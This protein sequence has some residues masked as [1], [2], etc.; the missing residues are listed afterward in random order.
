MGISLKTAIG[1][2]LDVFGK[3]QRNPRRPSEP[4]DQYRDR[5]INNHGDDGG[6]AFGE[7]QQVGNISLKT[8]GMSLRDYFAAAAAS[9]YT[10]NQEWMK[11]GRLH[12][13][14]LDTD[15]AVA[16]ASYEVADAML[17]ERAK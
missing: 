14:D 9:G 17:A 13:P 5:L 3:N 1:E 8:G 16:M 11:N 7:F 4:D 6:L 15:E 2:E 10:S 12:R